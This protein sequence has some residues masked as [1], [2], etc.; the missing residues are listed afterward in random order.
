MMSNEVRICC[1]EE[2]RIVRVMEASVPLEDYHV[3]LGFPAVGLAAGE[4]L[5][6]S[7]AVG[8][9]HFILFYF[10]ALT[11]KFGS[12]KERQT[13]MGIDII[14]DLLGYPK[15]SLAIFLFCFF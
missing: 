10:I 11:P 1:I 15:Q 3:H 6:F 7:H 4:E 14:S 2:Q 8:K 12:V 13:N 9:N 5:T